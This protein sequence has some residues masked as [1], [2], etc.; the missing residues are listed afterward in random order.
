[1]PKAEPRF[2]A[3]SWKQ[4]R[5]DMEYQTSNLPLEGKMLVIFIE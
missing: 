3:E 5:E 1:L 2:E 4:P